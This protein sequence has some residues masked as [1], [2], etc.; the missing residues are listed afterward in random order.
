MPI[1]QLQDKGNLS[2][3]SGDGCDFSTPSRTKQ[4]VAGPL[5]SF[6]TRPITLTVVNL[7]MQ[8]GMMCHT[9][10]LV[11]GPFRSFGTRAISLM[12]VDFDMSISTPSR[13]EHL[14]AGPFL[15]FR[16][17]ISLGFHLLPLWS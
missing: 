13:P 15:S 16:T 1:S 4:L 7:G 2:N 17:R 12:V 8:F 3:G 11:A 14:V 9:K 5:L 6:R 10:H